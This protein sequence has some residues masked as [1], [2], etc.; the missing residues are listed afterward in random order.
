MYAVLNMPTK[1]AAEGVR[2]PPAPTV[3]ND[4]RRATGKSF[5]NL[6][7]A[8]YALPKYRTIIATA[9]YNIPKLPTSENGANDD[10]FFMRHNGNKTAPVNP[11]VTGTFAAAMPAVDK[12][13]TKVSPK[14]IEYANVAKIVLSVTAVAGSQL[15]FGETVADHA[16][17]YE[18]VLVYAQHRPIN[19]NPYPDNAPIIEI[20]ATAGTTADGAL[21]NAAIP[22]GRLRT[23]APT[24][25]LTKL[26][27]SCVTVAP[28]VASSD[29]DDF[30]VPSS[31]PA[32]AA[33]AASDD[34]DS[35]KLFEL[36]KAKLLLLSSKLKPL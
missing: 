22:A 18:D 10:K 33:A 24:I 14:I 17:L 3:P 5:P 23:P 19:A 34:M 12:R 16:S 26:K 31:S 1:I 13:L 11:N 32:T 6:P 2:T 25:P 21:A 15:V 28:S 29:D 30:S 36:P 4:G 9:V 27:Q 8:T 20:S 7:V 35:I